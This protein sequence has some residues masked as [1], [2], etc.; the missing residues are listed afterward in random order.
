MNYE[1][2]IGLFLCI[3]L[4]VIAGCSKD[5]PQTDYPTDGLVSYFPFEGNL[6]DNYGDTEEGTAGTFG[7]FFVNGLHGQAIS[8]DGLTGNAYF[9]RST[10]RTDNRHSFS[11]WLKTDTHNDLGSVVICGDFFLNT[12]ANNVFYY[13]TRTNDL[14]GIS[15]AILDNT[16]MHIV[17]TYDG[18]SM[19]L[20]INNVQQNQSDLAGDL[21]GATTP[22]R[23]GGTVDQFWEGILDEL[24]FYDKVLSREEINLLFER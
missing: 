9:D 19:K 18:D 2:R 1:L 10:F 3:V 14:K 24:F 21:T 5:E 13:I 7:T 17:G 15:N 23:L 8:F 4:I 11:L 6:K 12:V 22:L 16:W 20:F